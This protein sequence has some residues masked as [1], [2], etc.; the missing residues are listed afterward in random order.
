MILKIT[1]GTRGREL[2]E[3]WKRLQNRELLAIVYRMT[4]ELIRRRHAH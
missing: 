3:M 1:E 2:F 4:L